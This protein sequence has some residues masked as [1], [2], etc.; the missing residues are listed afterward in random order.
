MKD[1]AE[2][3]K[4]IK[5]VLDSEGQPSPSGGGADQQPKAPAPAAT[6][7][8]KE[9]LMDEL[10]EI[11]ENIDHAKGEIGCPAVA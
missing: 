1:F 8:E 10:M 3:M 11:V 6:L 9:D 2:R 4:E 7:E 5:D